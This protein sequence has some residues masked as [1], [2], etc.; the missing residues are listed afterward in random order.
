M[1]DSTKG[2]LKSDISDQESQ[3]QTPAAPEQPAGQSTST[4]TASTATQPDDSTSGGNTNAT[5]Q[6]VPNNQTAAQSTPE[7]I[8]NSSSSSSAVSSTN[9]A[10]AKT[11]KGIRAKRKVR[12]NFP[13]PGEE[14][15]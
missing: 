11:R 2:E 7:P 3:S 1:S 9:V 4:G 12:S 5:S 13:R 8:N 15:Y 6:G 10:T 14:G